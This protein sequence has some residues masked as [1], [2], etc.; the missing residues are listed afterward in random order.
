MLKLKL[1]K[2]LLFSD[3]SEQ[4]KEIEVK[5]AELKKL[6]DKISNWNQRAKN[7]QSKFDFTLPNYIIDE[8]LENE[9]N[10]DYLNLY[11][12]INCALINGKISNEEAKK[13]K[14]FVD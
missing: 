12:L 14:Q 4:I 5:Q 1:K 13:I 8:I 6:Q 10:K 9:R 11:Y 2:F 3:F 7:I